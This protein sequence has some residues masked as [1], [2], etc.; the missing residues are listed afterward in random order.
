M[1]DF[2]SL[3]ALIVACGSIIVQI[4]NHIRSSKCCNDLIEIE[5]NDENRQL[6]LPLTQEEKS[7]L[8]NNQ[9]HAL[10]PPLTC[11]QNHRI[12]I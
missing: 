11:E 5:M 4:I 1:V 9:N 3:T 8:T 7:P 2:I 10:N 6:K 12:V